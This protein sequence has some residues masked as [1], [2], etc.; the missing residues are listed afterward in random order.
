MQARGR[1]G[2]A[3]LPACCWGQ[4][5][6]SRSEKGKQHLEVTKV[7]P[8]LI[9]MGHNSLLWLWGQASVRVT[10]KRRQESSPTQGLQTVTA[11][12][13]VVYSLLAACGFSHLTALLQQG[14]TW[15]SSEGQTKAETTEGL[16]SDNTWW[17]APSP[18]PPAPQ[19]PVP[20][21]A[22]ELSTC[23]RVCSIWSPS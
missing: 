7:S 5:Q 16:L 23:C 10:T 17:Q 8:V 15:A 2:A 20:Q 11:S 3:E 12:V 4:P 1:R 18:S 6:R 19:P 14:V 21:Y 22:A 13:L 9:L